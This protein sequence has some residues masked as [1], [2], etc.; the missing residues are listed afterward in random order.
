M[1]HELFLEVLRLDSGACESVCTMGI[2]S[3]PQ[4]PPGR[5]LAL[6]SFARMGNALATLDYLALGSSLSL[7]SYARVGPGRHARRARQKA[8]L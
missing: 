2:G 1:N 7:R 6:R 4:R 5:S 8:G 3:C